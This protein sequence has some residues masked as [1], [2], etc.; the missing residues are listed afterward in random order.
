[1]KMNKIEALVERIDDGVEMIV[2]SESM[3]DCTSAYVR[4][5]DCLAN[6]YLSIMK[7]HVKAGKDHMRL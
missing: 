4:A 6:L 2:N 1:M 5:M 3:T 7:K